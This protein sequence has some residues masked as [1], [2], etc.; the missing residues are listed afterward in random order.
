MFGSDHKPLGSAEP[1]RAFSFL[2]MILGSISVLL[3]FRPGHTPE[4]WDV[5]MGGLWIALG[6]L[7]LLGGRKRRE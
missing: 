6:F 7:Y 4:R 5:F 2:F 3:Q 1:P